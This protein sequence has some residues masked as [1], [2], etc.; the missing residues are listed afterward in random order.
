[1][2]ISLRYAIIILIVGVGSIGCSELEKKSQV[3]SD[4]IHNKPTT[5]QTTHENRAVSGNKKAKRAKKTHSAVFLKKTI[6]K[7]KELV[8]KPDFTRREGQALVLQY[9][10]D[11]CILDIFFYGEN[12]TKVS[13]YFEFRPR[14]NIKINVQ[15]CRNRML[16]RKK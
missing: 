1:M 16:T 9:Q 3:I 13:T 15:K 7:V 11:L 8:G 12:G 2:K 10:T 4:I 6:L 14:T 5:E